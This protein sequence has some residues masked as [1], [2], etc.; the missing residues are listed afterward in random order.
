MGERP[1]ERTANKN[2][3]KMKKVLIVGSGL[4]GLATAMRLAKKDYQIE[5]V[6]KFHQ[7]GG[8]LNCI[9]K[10]GF[11]F[12]T[13]PSFFSMSYE[14]N[15]FAA[16]CNITLPFS[17]VELDPLYTVNFLGNPRKF[18]IYKD[19]K[20][21]AVEFEDIEP[22]FE[23]KVTRYLNSAGHFFHSSIDIV[24][25]KNYA[26]I[27][28][29][30]LQMLTVPKRH[31][32]KIMLNMWQEVSRNFSS[33][34][35]RQIFSLVAF[36][37][38][39]TPF[40]TLGVYSLLSYTELVHDGY[41]NVKGGMYE[42][43]KG[44]VELLEKENVK[45][46]YNTEITD[47][48]YNNNRLE[49]LVDST[50]KVWQA[51]IFVINAD[52]AFFRGKVFRRKAFSEEKLN[53]M[54]WT[55]APFT[56]YL[57][58]KGKI[59]SLDHHNYFLGKDFKQYA[60]DIFKSPV[61]KEHPYYY[62]NTLSKFN[63]ESAPEGCE[64]LFIVCPV[65]DLRYKKQWDDKMQFADS[66][67]NDLSQ[68]IGF[69]ITENILVK[70]IMTPIDWQ[71]NF[72]LYKGSGLG[73]AHNLTQIGAFRPSNADE[74]FKNV[75]YVGASTVPGTGLPMTLIGAKLTEQRLLEYDR[76]V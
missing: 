3:R 59:P 75:F 44:L 19:L 61:A 63:P 5:I 73:L 8:R 40:N 10:D 24:I 51:D 72:N 35:A 4:G 11:T 52:A 45:I 67:I 42:I 65:S 21:L 36:F 56:M 76:P 6:E 20:K 22:D 62:V 25:K 17:F 34:E 54:N 7:A 37:L 13:G 71:N 74:E 15:E 49:Q 48:I 41:Y 70:E 12:D 66:I 27:S 43:T 28:H 9:R 2:A 14:F 50:G 26:S 55:F 64:A 69:N 29:F 16:D 68:R 53:K 38:G 33:N 46:H 39:E 57:G 32:P 23:Q 31:I 18:T 47:Y 60:K 58:I 1:V 30:L